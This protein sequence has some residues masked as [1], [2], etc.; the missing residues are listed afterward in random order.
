MIKNS[1]FVQVSHYS[2]TT[3]ESLIYE[4]DLP[5]ARP[6]VHVRVCIENALDFSVTATFRSPGGNVS[7]LGDLLSPPFKALWKTSAMTDLF[8]TKRLAIGAY[9]TDDTGDALVANTNKLLVWL[10]AVSVCRSVYPKQPQLLNAL[11][12]GHNTVE[13][14]Q[15]VAATGQQSDA[16]FVTEA[17]VARTTEWDVHAPGCVLLVIGRCRTCKGNS[18]PHLLRRFERIA[19]SVPQAAPPDEPRLLGDAVDREQLAAVARNSNDPNEQLLAHLVLDASCVVP[20]VT[21]RRPFDSTVHNLASNIYRMTGVNSY[22]ALREI[23]PFRLPSSSSVR[24]TNAA[25]NGVRTA[26]SLVLEIVALKK[27][28]EAAADAMTVLPRACARELVLGFVVVAFDC[29]CMRNCL[30]AQRGAHNNGVFAGVAVPNVATQLIHSDDDMLSSCQR[31]ATAVITF[32][33]RSVFSGVCGVAAV[34]PVAESEPP[35]TVIAPCLARVLSLLQ[36]SG[37]GVVCTTRDSATAHLRMD[38]YRSGTAVDMQDLQ[39][40]FSSFV[41]DRAKR[42]AAGEPLDV[43]DG[44]AALG[45]AATSIAIAGTGIRAGCAYRMRGGGRG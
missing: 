40:A 22:D 35:A 18:K 26:L 45:D 23:L 6:K 21:S 10:S 5:V 2:S 41:A 13:A 14:I 29:M 15:L 9:V 25:R 36:A 27:Q 31:V 43:A 7:V 38:M 19:S 12:L 3:L 11:P 30:V 34:V 28:F 44:D 4:A 20:G 8:D 32:T 1:N 17:S 24:S 33:V 42:R 39:L 16:Y 37:F